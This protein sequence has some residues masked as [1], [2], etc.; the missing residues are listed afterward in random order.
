MKTLIGLRTSHKHGQPVL[1]QRGGTAAVKFEG[2]W[3]RGVQPN[4]AVSVAGLAGL[5]PA[6]L[7]G[8]AAPE[9]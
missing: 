5:F 4:G 9:F 2:Q 7:Q 6:Q 1:V 8:L 3:N